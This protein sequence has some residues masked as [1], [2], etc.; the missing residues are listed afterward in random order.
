MLTNISRKTV[1][2]ILY[3]G[4]SGAIGRERVGITT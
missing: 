4:K 2:Y 3:V 1:S